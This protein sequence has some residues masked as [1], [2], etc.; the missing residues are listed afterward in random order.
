MPTFRIPAIYTITKIYQIE[1]ENI[2]AAF[3]IVR[4]MC[5]F[6]EF[7]EPEWD[8]VFIDEDAAQEI[9]DGDNGQSP[10][11]CSTTSPT[12]QIVLQSYTVS[13]KVYYHRYTE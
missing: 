7:E 8:T 6:E 11:K 5:P 3:G 13:N 9:A 4:S 1:A 12:R 10:N 2:G